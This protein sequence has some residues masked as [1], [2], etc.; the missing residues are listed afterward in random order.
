MRRD[1]RYFWSSAGAACLFGLTRE[2]EIRVARRRPDAGR[3]GDG[4]RLSPKSQ[5]PI[6]KSQGPYVGIWTLGFGIWDLVMI[7]RHE[8]LRIF[9]DAG[10]T[11][12]E[13][14]VPES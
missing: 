2:G 4:S 9:L 14:P 8:M 13:R 1:S 3:N 7:Q 11:F 5:G 6:P 12:F 10:W